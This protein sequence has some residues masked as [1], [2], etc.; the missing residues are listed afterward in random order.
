MSIIAALAGVMAI[1]PVAVLVGNTARVQGIAED[2]TR[3]YYT[4]D[5]AVHA[6]IEDLVRGRCCLPAQPPGQSPFNP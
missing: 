2:T 1:V 6:V 5:A 4:S 3:D